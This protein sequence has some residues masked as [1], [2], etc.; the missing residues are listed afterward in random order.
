[1]TIQTQIQSRGTATPWIEIWAMPF[2][3]LPTFMNTII[4]LIDDPL[5]RSAFILLQNQSILSN[6]ETIVRNSKGNH[7]KLRRSFN[8]ALS[9]AISTTMNFNNELRTN[10]KSNGSEN[11][12]T[13]CYIREK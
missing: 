12:D 1:M 11:K 5:A 13:I 2:K 7:L 9:N 3:T 10:K 6:V 4:N 8:S